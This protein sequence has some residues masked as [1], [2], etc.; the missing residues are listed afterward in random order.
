[1]II[2]A[3]VGPGDSKYTTL[4][5]LDAIKNTPNVV[6]FNRVS[7]SLIDIRSDYI[8]VSTVKEVLSCIEKYEEILILASGDPC[9]YGIL[10]YLKK[11]EVKVD[12]VL[13]GLSS[14][15][16]MMS[17]LNKSWHKA[18]FLSLHGRETNLEEVKNNPLTIILTDK[19]N[20]PSSIS[21]RLKDLGMKG[22]IYAG[23]NLSYTDEL[24]VEKDIGEKIEDIS[25]LAVVVIE[26]EMDKR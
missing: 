5:V 23:Y 17:K 16:Y 21:E 12:K 20:T 13:P 26:N 1:M 15:Q 19:E 6:A 9:F 18:A 14:F 11:K 2:V 22:T 3:G 10:E 4:D 8:K 7:E 25:S 24:I